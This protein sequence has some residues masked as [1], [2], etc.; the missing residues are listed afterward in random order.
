MFEQGVCVVA[1][2]GVTRN[3][4]AGGRV[5]LAAAGDEGAGELR[6]DLL[7]GR[8]DV[9]VVVSAGE[10]RRELITTHPGDSVRFSYGFT[11]ALGD[12]LQELV[13]DRMTEAV[14]DRLEAVEI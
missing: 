1:V 9:G 11:E 10:E 2:G 8:R 6:D 5:Q 3:A 14:V 12:S 13:A 7:G 4:D